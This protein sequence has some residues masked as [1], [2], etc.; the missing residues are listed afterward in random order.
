MGSLYQHFIAQIAK[1]RKKQPEEVMNIAN[2]LLIQSPDDALKLGMITGIKY[3]DELMDEFRKKIGVKD[4]AKIDFVTLGTYAKHAKDKN[5]KITSKQKIALVYADGSIMDGE[6]D[7]ETIGS[8]TFCQALEKARNDSSVKA[9]VLRI[10]SPG[11]SA[12]ASDVMWR[13]VILAKKVKPVVVS[14]G[15]VAASGGYYIAA[16]ADKIFAQPNTITGSIGV[17]AVLMNAQKLL[18]DKLG[19]N[20]QTVNFGKYAD[21]GNASRPLSADEKV[22]LQKAIDRIYT[23]FTTKVAEGRSLTLEHVDSIAQG[24]VY[25]G[26]DAMTIGLVDEIG[27]LQDAIAYA[28]KK[29]NMDEYRILSL[30]ENEDTFKN[31][32]KSIT[33]ESSTYLNEMRYGEFYPLYQQVNKAL[34][35]K[36]IQTRMPFSIEIN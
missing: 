34:Q 17:F 1:A 36:G 33:S 6:S 9:I 31:L 27:S 22:I 28:A 19:I 30:P 15:S 35:Y 20:M 13:E 25:S 2:N 16:P 21:I 23:D 5:N 29:A 24:R 7:D 14:F 26:N 11:G 10:N 12:L 3:R 32:L 8:V 18:K 4:G